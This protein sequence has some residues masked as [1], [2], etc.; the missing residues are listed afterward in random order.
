VNRELELEPSE[1]V[2][3]DESE[4]LLLTGELS[5]SASSDNGERVS[6]E[7]ELSESLSSEESERLSLKR[8][9]S[10]VIERE[11]SSDCNDRDDVKDEL[12]PK[13]SVIGG[14]IDS[15]NDR[16]RTN[17]CDSMK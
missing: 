12:T 7:L 17:E 14:G 11:A 13:M 8:E 6:L 9:L 3:L 16:E 5:E 15:E 1:I 10:V 4:T 2:G